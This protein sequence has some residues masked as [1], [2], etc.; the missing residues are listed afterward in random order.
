MI[1]FCSVNVYLVPTITR[2]CKNLFYYIS[3]T[4]VD[5]WWSHQYC[6]HWLHLCLADAL[7]SPSFQ[8]SGMAQYKNTWVSLIGSGGRFPRFVSPNHFDSWL[9]AQGGILELIIE[10]YI[11]CLFVGYVVMDSLHQRR[12]ESRQ[13]TR[14]TGEIGHQRK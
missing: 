10:W 14:R 13:R 1:I 7:S 4:T 8:I 12:D 9:S 5:L 3:N 11:C 6:R 2:N